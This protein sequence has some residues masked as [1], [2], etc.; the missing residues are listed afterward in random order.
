MGIQM[1]TL[2]DIGR[3]FKHTNAFGMT[4]YECRQCNAKY[5][6]RPEG[7]NTYHVEYPNGNRYRIFTYVS[8]W[9][10]INRPSPDCQVAAVAWTVDGHAYDSLELSSNKLIDLGAETLYLVNGECYQRS[11]GQVQDW[12]PS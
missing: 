8:D 11:I 2:L 1:C 4:T 12:R 3:F 10:L 5:F 7:K 6:K 9:P